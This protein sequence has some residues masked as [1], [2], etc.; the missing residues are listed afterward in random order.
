MELKATVTAKGAIFEGKAPE[1]VRKD[2]LSA[3]HEATAFLEGKVKENAPTGVYGTQGGL[4][5]TIH[6]EVVEHGDAVTGIVGHQSK[7]GDVI[8]M[9]RRPGQ[10]MPPA[11]TLLRWVEIK[12]GLTG[13]PARQVEFLIR[14]KIG[15]KGFEGAHMFEKAW[16]ENQD[17]LKRI[18]DRAGFDIALHLKEG[19]S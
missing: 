17:A 5:A 12:T 19:K 2:L 11:G 18:F 1:I 15:K 6:G 16:N 9:G 10:K 8:E 13:K 14:R 7:Y 4:V 3:M